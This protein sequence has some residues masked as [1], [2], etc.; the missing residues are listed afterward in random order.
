MHALPQAFYLPTPGGQLFCLYHP[1]VGMARGRVLHL[2]PLAE[3]LNNCRRVSAQQ[4]RAL[5]LA[6]YAVL[7]FDMSGCG[8]SAGEFAEASW[9]QWLLDVSSAADWLLKQE[10]GPLWLW[11]VRTGALL[12]T[13]WLKNQAS[14]QVVPTGTPVHLLFWQAILSG[15]QALKHWSRLRSATT[16]VGGSERPSSVFMSLQTHQSSPTDTWSV[17]GYTFN[18]E[19]Q[20]GLGQTV[21]QPPENTPPQRLVWVDVTTT[22]PP[23]TSPGAQRALEAW[24]Q[25]GWVVQ[26]VATAGPSYWQTIGTD[27]APDLQSNTLALLNHGA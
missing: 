1:P 21:L 20:E 16:W 6:G 5:A 14:R 4:A 3:E 27:D 10:Q 12:A 9:A 8:D 19:L 2:H 13:D 23:L 7:Q 25:A 11:G 24:Q 22:T 17:A 26:A 18:P 15:Q